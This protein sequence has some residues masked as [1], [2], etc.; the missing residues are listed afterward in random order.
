MSYDDHYY[1]EYCDSVFCEKELLE[2]Y[3]SLNNVTDK[4]CPECDLPVIPYSQY[5]EQQIDDILAMWD[6]NPDPQN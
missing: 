6:A 3:D 1:C 4:M 2:E 5:R